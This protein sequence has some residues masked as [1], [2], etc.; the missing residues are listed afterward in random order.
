MLLHSE[1]E[2]WYEYQP[3]QMIEDVSHKIY[4]FSLQGDRVIAAR[5]LDHIVMNKKSRK[6]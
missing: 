5:I 1:K 6:C 3:E 4:V 2:K